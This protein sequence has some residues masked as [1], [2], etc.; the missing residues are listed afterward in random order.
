MDIDKLFEFVECDKGYILKGYLLKDDNSVTEAEIP[1]E[2]KGLPVISIGFEAFMNAN[3]LY[4]VN[5]SEG[6]EEIGTKAFYSCENLKTVLLP[7]SIRA[8]RRFSFN[9]CRKLENI[10]FPNGLEVIDEYS[11]FSCRS[12]KSVIFPSSLTELGKAAFCDC[13]GLESVVFPKELE[14]IGAFAFQDCVKLNSVVLPE[15]LKAI[16]VHLF[17]NC[18]NLESIDLPDSLKEIGS[19]AFDLC[20]LR[21]VRLPSG[22]ERIG[23]LAFFFCLNLERVEFQNSSTLLET[24]VFADCP[25]LAAENVLQGLIGSS[26]ITKAFAYS[27]EFDWNSALREDVFALALKYDSF[28]LFDKEKI[29]G[30]IVRR[31]LNRLLPLTEAAGWSITGECIGD[32]LDISLK[33]G[34]VEITAWLLDYKNRKTGFKK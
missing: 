11:F 4:S 7:D 16:S 2:Y 26:D 5:V 1:S 17:K 32:L 3:H 34:F 21:S 15:K 9:N 8:I 20:G 14:N 28:A 10:L 23:E 29:L 13:A 22:L 25:K 31:N 6:I 33:N 19:Y 18:R 27:E 24:R 30:E 12:I